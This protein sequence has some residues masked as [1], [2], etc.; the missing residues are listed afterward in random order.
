MSAAKCLS[1]RMLNFKMVKETACTCES[2]RAIE[3]LKMLIIY[4][5]NFFRYQKLVHLLARIVCRV[6]YVF[7]KCSFV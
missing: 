1:K 2:F 3:A 6:Q 4:L 7:R 5:R